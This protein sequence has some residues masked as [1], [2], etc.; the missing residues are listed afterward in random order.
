[1]MI[2]VL[3]DARS[4]GAFEPLLDAFEPGAL[5]SPPADAAFLDD[6]ADSIFAAGARLPCP[7]VLVSLNPKPCTTWQAQSLQGVHLCL[8]CCS[9]NPHRRPLNLC[10]GFASA[11]P[12]VHVNLTA[13]H[14]VYTSGMGCPL[15][16]SVMCALSYAPG[17]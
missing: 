1:M 4:R 7:A 11:C 9:Y 3:C 5:A 2:V 16:T 14:F 6:L 15:Y 10:S 12:A 13:C 17:S 8:P